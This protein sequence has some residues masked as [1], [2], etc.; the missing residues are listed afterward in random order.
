MT[1]LIEALEAIPWYWKLAP[2]IHKL[3]QGYNWQ[4]F[5][6][7]AVE[8]KSQLIRKGKVAVFN[9][10]GKRYEIQPTG[11]GLILGKQFND[12]FLITIDCDGKAAYHKLIEINCNKYETHNLL[13]TAH[14]L[15]PPTAAWTSGKPYRAQYLYK[16]PNSNKWRSQII[17]TSNSNEMLEF[18]GTNMLSVIP[19][20][21]HP[22]GRKY[23]FLSY[24]NINN[25]HAANAPDWIIKIVGENKA[26]ANNK[27]SYN[28]SNN[29]Q[30]SSI[31]TSH[32]IQ[33]AR[34]LLDNIHP[35]YADNYWSWLRIGIALHNISDK[36][37]LT[38]WDNWS[39]MSSKYKPGECSLKWA[40][41]ARSPNKG[42]ISIKTLKYYVSHFS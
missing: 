25:F 20:S 31:S 2:T 19:P 7:S 42:K 6:F 26:K 9:R 35:R 12:E 27:R 21:L 18:R 24:W 16:L 11:I 33:Q 4:Q 1:S 39:A 28:I 10:N 13:E 29:Y 41:F 34:L 14:S 8:L 32:R 5:P 22:E 36:E 40:S 38:D 23:Q 17:K 15:L 30:P 3:S 37:L